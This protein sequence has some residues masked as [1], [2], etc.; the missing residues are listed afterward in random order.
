MTTTF[1]NPRDVHAPVGPYS[2]TAVVRAGPELVFTSGQVGMRPDGST[3]DD[4]AE[5][6]ELT[7]L[8]LRAC[9]AAHGLGLDA[10]VKLTAF[11]VPGQDF[12]LLRTARQFDWPRVRVEDLLALVTQ[13]VALARTSPHSI[14]AH[15]ALTAYLRAFRAFSSTSQSDWERVEA[16]ERAR[17]Q[18]DQPL[19]QLADSARTAR[20]ES[21]WRNLAC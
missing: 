6:C 5:Q 11:V 17:W 18:R 15:L 21:A 14:A 9:L 8:N 16:D 3:P 1:T 7:F 19:M 4:F 13:G 2:H 10:V 12:Q 20:T